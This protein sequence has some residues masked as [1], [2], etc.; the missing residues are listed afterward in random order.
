MVRG[1]DRTLEELGKEKIIKIFCIKHFLHGRI[2]L[3]P[4]FLLTL[5]A[6]SIRLPPILVVGY[7][8][9]A[10]GLNQLAYPGNFRKLKWNC[11]SSFYL[12]FKNL[13]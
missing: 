3:S 6:L 7:N 9:S 10:F 1:I 8:S 13:T 12:L 2:F 4:E 5:A 11:I